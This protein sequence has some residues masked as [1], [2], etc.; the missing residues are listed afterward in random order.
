MF[1][2]EVKIKLA[3]GGDRDTLRAFCRIVINGEFAISDLKVIQSPSGLFVAMPSKRVTVRCRQCGEKVPVKVRFCWRCGIEEPVLETDIQI[4][5]RGRQKLHTDI[6][7]PI[8][9]E[10]REAITRAVVAAYEA[11]V[12]LAALPGYECRY[13]DYNGEE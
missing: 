10:C 2:S 1:I 12:E 8:R 4:D 3:R 9:R 7:H 5:E 13:G 6:A 11:E